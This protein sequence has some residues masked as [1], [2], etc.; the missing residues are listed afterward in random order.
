MG[1]ARIITQKCQ[2]ALLGKVSF[3][4]AL[5][6]AEFKALPLQCGRVL[7]RATRGKQ[8]RPAANPGL[9]QLDA[10]HEKWAHACVAHAKRDSD[11]YVPAIIV[12]YRCAQVAPQ[13]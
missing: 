10:S 3:E 12:K 4:L 5:P 11:A 6:R 2:R 1:Y 8:A 13:T 7:R 9:V